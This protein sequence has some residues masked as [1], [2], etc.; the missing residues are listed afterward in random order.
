MLPKTNNTDLYKKIQK[1]SDIRIIGLIAFGIVV[2]L[3]AWSSLRVLQ[4]NYE[5]EKQEAGLA[6]KNQI[7]KLENENLR[8]RN[9]YYESDEYLELSARRQ[10][11]K[12][13]PGERLFLIPA[14]VAKVHTVNLPK[15]EKEIQAGKEQNKPEFQQNLEAWR[16]FFFHINRN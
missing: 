8:L 3:V 15:T 7:Q 4:V 11:N 9:V 14:S 1:Y 13:A 16:N 2:L 12:A 10:L 5:L 6:Q